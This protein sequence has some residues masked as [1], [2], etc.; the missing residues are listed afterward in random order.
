[1]M[2][3][4]E[5]RCRNIT[6]PQASFCGTAASRLT[7]FL[8]FFSREIERAIFRSGP[9]PDS[10]SDCICK[11]S[12]HLPPAAGQHSEAKWQRS[13]KI[14]AATWPSRSTCMLLKFA[15]PWHCSSKTATI[16]L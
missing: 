13:A 2:Q 14:G 12:A 11:W 3:V 6:Y 1:L 8:L 7:T 16:P 4:N 15:G 9:W 5:D 10:A